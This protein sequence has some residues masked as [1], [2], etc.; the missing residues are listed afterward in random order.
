MLVS[1]L[2]TGVTSDISMKTNSE[3]VAV[4]WRGLCIMRTR[5]AL[6]D[7]RLLLRNRSDVATCRVGSGSVIKKY[8]NGSAAVKLFLF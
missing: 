6:K 3:T 2:Y 4:I 7:F 8:I 5:H 1:Q